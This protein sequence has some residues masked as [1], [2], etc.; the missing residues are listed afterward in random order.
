MGV[1]WASADIATG[2]L[3]AN[4]DK[5]EQVLRKTRIDTRHGFGELRTHEIRSSGLEQVIVLFMFGVRA[6][7]VC[8]SGGGG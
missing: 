8:I 2:K 1:S 6:F 7:L 4:A 3:S 5:I